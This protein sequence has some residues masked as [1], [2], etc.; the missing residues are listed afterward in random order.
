MVEAFVGLVGGGKS[1]SSVKRMCN[2]IAKGGVVVTNI[3]FSGYDVES[4]TFSEDA[5]LLAYLRNRYKWEY[6]P[7]QYIYISFDE[8]CTLPA[9]FRRV[10]GGVSRDKRT[11]L[12]ID[13]AT[14]LFD[15]LDR[16]KLNN[17]SIYRE[18]FRFLRLSRHA[19]IDVL[20]VCQDLN[21]INSRL[22][23]LVSF[24]WRSTDMKNF[25]IGGLRL[26]L[27]VNCFLLQ[28]FDRTGKFELRREFVAKEQSVFS[29]YQSEAFHDA[30]GITFSEPV[31]NGRI[32]ERKKRMSKFERVLFYI[33]LALAFVLIF[34]LIS[35]EGKINYLSENLS[36][37][38]D[39][40]V[41]S[42]NKSGA[43]NLPRNPGEIRPAQDTPVS[44]VK[45]VIVRGVFE[46]VGANSGNYCYV[47]GSLFRPGLLTEYGLCKSVTK[48]TI[49]CID[50]LTETVIVPRLG[51]ASGV[52]FQAVPDES[53]ASAL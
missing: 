17:D 40:P 39:Y 25:R 4:E 23:G 50:G 7:K 9:W 27:P 46:F 30:L 18:L 28:Q 14:D 3:L 41:I 29:L 36:Q 5:P 2:Y 37:K 48:N 24:I 51:R 38:A 13:E 45:R 16:G 12:C 47:D 44:N 21:A 8:M 11:F 34:K 49:I 52:S 6:Q 15:T 31:Q 10:P 32:V 43:E 20:F 42:E 1:Y 53:G 33:L 22:R 35:L 26:A 19:H